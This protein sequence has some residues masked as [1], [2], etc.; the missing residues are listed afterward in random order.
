[1]TKNLW[2]GE[3]PFTCFFSP[4][5][6]E[7]RVRSNNGLSPSPFHSSPFRVNLQDEPIERER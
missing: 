3:N 1:V 7:I 4:L 6:G 5:V 2:E